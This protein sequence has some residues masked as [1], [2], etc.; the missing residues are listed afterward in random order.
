MTLYRIY[1]SY[2]CYYWQFLVRYFTNMVLSAKKLQYIY[3]IY[4]CQCWLQFMN[5]PDIFLIH[6]LLPIAISLEIFF[7]FLPLGHYSIFTLSLIFSFIIFF[8]S[9][10]KQ[11][12]LVIAQRNSLYS[13][14][15]IFVTILWSW[16]FIFIII[17]NY[18]NLS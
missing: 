14:M 3:L 8:F 5:Y 16:I 18:I 6:I 13:E 4:I 1:F 12:H 7:C 10:L 15:L 11:I 2:A 9:T 17:F